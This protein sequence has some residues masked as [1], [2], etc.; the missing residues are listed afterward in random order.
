MADRQQSR[1]SSLKVFAKISGSRPPKPPPKDQFYIQSSASSVS[2]APSHTQ[3]LA[4]FAS[5][6]SSASSDRLAVPPHAPVSSPPTNAQHVPIGRS[7]S[8]SQS[9]HYTT[10]T[11]S[12]PPT[13]A[14]GSFLTPDSGGSALKKGFSKLSSLSKRPFALKP[15]SSKTFP[16][17]R[18]SASQI[19]VTSAAPEP[20]DDG[21]ISFPLSFK[22]R[23]LPLTQLIRVLITF[24]Q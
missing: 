7:R 20:V 21:S 19:D 3:S 9:S 1:F 8:P 5:S 23:V 22:V 16:P 14:S 4:R 24:S 18:S 12:S 11:Y 10:Q 15:Q 13:S 17:L 2:L 6:Y